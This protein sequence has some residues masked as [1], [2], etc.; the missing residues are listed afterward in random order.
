MAFP[1]TNCLREIVCLVGQVAGEAPH[2]RVQVITGCP[3]SLGNS[4]ALG[5][6][7]DGSHSG[8]QGHASP[9]TPVWPLPSSVGSCQPGP[10]GSRA[11]VSHS[12]QSPFSLLLSE[13]P[14]PRSIHS[15]SAI[16]QAVPDRSQN[17]ARTQPLLQQHNRLLK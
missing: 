1:G 11:L 2:L 7:A 5:R 14:R 10:G 3:V 4:A 13:N 12:H 15:F 17:G 16:P 9:P 8:L 6:A